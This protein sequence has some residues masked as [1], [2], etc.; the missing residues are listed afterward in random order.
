MIDEKYR[1]Y[2]FDGDRYDNDYYIKQKYQNLDLHERILKHLDEDI[3]FKH[4]NFSNMKF[5]Y[6]E[7]LNNDEFVINGLWYTMIISGAIQNKC[8]ISLLISEFGLKENEYKYINDIFNDY[9]DTDILFFDRKG[10]QIDKITMCI[11]PRIRI[12]GNDLRNKIIEINFRLKSRLIYRY[13]YKHISTNPIQNLILFMSHNISNIVYNTYKRNK[14]EKRF[15][16]ELG[17]ITFSKGEDPPEWKINRF[18]LK[19]MK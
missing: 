2:D 4:I 15:T 17:Y 6:I 7:Y 5:Y 12:Y 18:P 10:N 11:D 3:D 16:K 19:D 9:G 8:R 13:S 14:I 1:I